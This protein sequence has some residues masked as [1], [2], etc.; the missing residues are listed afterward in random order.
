MTS[1]ILAPYRPRLTLK[2][3]GEF[4]RFLGWTTATQ[5]IGALLW[6]S[7]KLVLGQ[8]VPSSGV[9]QFSMGND[10]ATLP[11][12]ILISPLS[13]VLLPAF[14]IIKNDLER[15]R[16]S[17]LKTLR[18]IVAIGVPILVALCFVA[19]PA[20]FLML[21]PKWAVAAF[22]LQ[23]LSIAFIPSMFVAGMGPLAMALDQTHLL[24]RR[25]LYELSFKLPLITLGAFY[26]GLEGLLFATGLSAA[27]IG[28]M[29]LSFVRLCI[30]LPIMAQLAAPWRTYLSLLPM[31]AVLIITRGWTTGS[32]VAQMIGLSTSLILA[33]IAY[34]GAAASLWVATG[35]I[36]GFEDLVM[37]AVKR[38]MR[39]SRRAGRVAQ[40]ITPDASPEARR[41]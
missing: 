2:H 18:T 27:V 20:T 28:F 25:S 33:G 26:D 10:L 9:G 34:L 21:G 3:I 30:D 8:F 40:V 36:G 24:F 35:R 14:S 31:C 13:A 29:S 7:D 5:F 1:Y 12:R 23:V 39:R 4:Y 6:Q 19:K 15:L 17:Y 16:S 41:T 37:T 38:L 32:G 22:G 11:A